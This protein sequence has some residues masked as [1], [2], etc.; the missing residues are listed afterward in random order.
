M[1]GV[2]LPKKESGLN[3]KEERGNLLLAARVLIG[4]FHVATV[5][6]E[7]EWRYPKK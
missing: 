5:Y 3:V 4:S 2:Q 1:N 6:R 7:P